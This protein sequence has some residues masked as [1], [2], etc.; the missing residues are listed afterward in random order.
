MNTDKRNGK[1]KMENGGWRMENFGFARE[2]GKE[3]G[4]A[5]ARNF[6]K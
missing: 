4:L 2:Q 5:D 6:K 1:W 3:Q